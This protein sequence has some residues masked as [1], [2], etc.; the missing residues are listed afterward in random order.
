[1]RPVPVPPVTQDKVTDNPKDKDDV[2]T[3]SEGSFICIGNILEEDKE[4]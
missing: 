3:A 2:P 1:M 4:M